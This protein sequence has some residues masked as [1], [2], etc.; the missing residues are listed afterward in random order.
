M[1]EVRH[2]RKQYDG[3]VA[4]A[5]LNLS[6]PAGEVYGL[7]GPN[8]AGKTT[9]IRIL[10]TLL[11]PTYGQVTI[12]GIDVC[13]RPLDVH[14]L[15]GYMS[16]FF[17]LYDDM[18]V[19]EYLDHFAGCYRIE[20]SRRKQLIDDV[21]ELVSLEVRRDDKIKALSRGMRQRLC[22]AKTLLHQPQVL[23]LDEPASGLDPA[24]RIEF[25]EILKK[26]HEMGRTVLI[27]SHI[28][29]EMADFCTSIGIV[30]QGQLLASGRVEDILR[31][32]QS[33]MRL[34][35][36]V[37][38]GQTLQLAQ[39]LEQE[40]AAEKVDHSNGQLTCTWGGSRDELPALHRRIVNQGIPLVSFSIERDNLE[41]IYMH[42]SG[43][44][45]S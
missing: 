27:S 32:L 13:E 12:G 33:R 26:L 37:A 1:I 17:S 7:I 38:D 3:K 41:D 44:R 9:L 18:L 25:R 43:H 14:P 42:I 34:V 31:Q 20:R 4:I 24:G 15:I 45:T 29:T 35:I 11:E 21:L 10:A 16:D 40:V 28:L 2:L 6:I 5:N 30:E 19:W 36:E 8:G 39:L 23:L 22:F